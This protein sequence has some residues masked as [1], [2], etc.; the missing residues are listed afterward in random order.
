MGAGELYWS[1]VIPSESNYLLFAFDEHPS[2]WLVVCV[3]DF[4]R[5][6]YEASV[7]LKV[8]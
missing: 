8:L 7:G 1:D 2:E 3:T 4:S 5:D 6:A